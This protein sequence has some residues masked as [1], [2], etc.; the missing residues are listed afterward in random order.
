M[1]DPITFDPALVSPWPVEPARQLARNDAGEVRA[2]EAA[3][4]LM[5][6]TKAAEPSPVEAQQTLLNDMMTEMRLQ[7]EAFRKIRVDAEKVL[8]APADEAAAKLAK[9]DIKAA[10][11]ALSLIVRTIEKIDSL[12]RSLADDRERAAERDFDQAAYDEL[13]AG[14]ERKIEARARELAAEMVVAQNAEAIAGNGTGPPFR[15]S[16]EGSEPADD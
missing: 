9:A 7:F 13:V 14:I 8:E 10:N 5:L 16:G 4:L 6:E 3:D 11:D 12:Q 1:F 15:S 2:R